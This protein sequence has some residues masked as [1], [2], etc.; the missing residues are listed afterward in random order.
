M[1]SKRRARTPESSFFRKSSCSIC[2]VVK[3]FGGQCALPS[4]LRG[5]PT[6][7]GGVGWENLENLGGPKNFVAPVEV[8]AVP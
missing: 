3:V 5:D 2:R 4:L 1:Y 6:V 7:L 8:R